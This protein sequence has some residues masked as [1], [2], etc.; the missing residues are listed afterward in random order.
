M[1]TTIDLLI[2]DWIQNH[3]RCGLLDRIVPAI[4]MLGEAGWIWI[5]AG[6]VPAD[7]PENEKI[8]AG[9]EH[10][11][12]SGSAAVQ[13]SAEAAGGP[14]TTLYPSAGYHPADKKAAG[15]LLPLGPCGSVLCGGI[16]AGIFSLSALAACH[17]AGG[18]HFSEPPV[19][20][21]TLSQ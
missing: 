5:P 18:A 4:T 11:T 2:L 15:L 21:C 8:R 13:C 17:G 14:S 6:T 3:L 1:I 10:C 16:G 19:S 12:G 20:L 9:G 7:S